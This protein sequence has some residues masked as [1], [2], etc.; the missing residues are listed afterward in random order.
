MPKN[1]KTLKKTI[2]LLFFVLIVCF[3][4]TVPLHYTN[5]QEGNVDLSNTDI[6]DSPGVDNNTSFD[7]EDW[8]AFY[9]ENDG[10]EA[11]ERREEAATTAA[12]NYEPGLWDFTGHLKNFV[13]VLANFLLRVSAWFLG[14]VGLILNTVVFFSIENMSMIVDGG[15]MKDTWTIFRDLL[16]ILFIFG[17]LFISIKT[18][19][20]TWGS[21]TKN[22]L[23]NI[24][25]AG[26]LINFSFFFTSVFIDLS[27]IVTV[28]IYDGMTECRSTANSTRGASEGL[29]WVS[30]KGL[31]DCWVNAL[32]L[33]SVY[34]V[35]EAG[36]I[37]GVTSNSS[38]EFFSILQALFLGSAVITVAAIVFGV[39]AVTL[40]VRFVVLVFLL[41]TSPVMFAGMILP[42]LKGITSKWLSALQSNLLFAPLAFLFIFIAY[43]ITVTTNLLSTSVGSN[44]QSM[45]GW[46]K[47]FSA[48]GTQTIQVLMN[49]FIIIVFLVSA[50]IIAK[51]VGNAITSKS[52]S[53]GGKLV[54][55]GILGGAAALG[56]NTIGRGA[57][58]LAGNMKG[59]SRLALKTKATL[60]SVGDSS[61]NARN[62]RPFKGIASA[63]GIDLGADKKGGFASRQ[64][65][66]AKAIQETYKDLGKMTP[67]DLVEV[68]KLKQQMNIE[69]ADEINERK[70][71]EKRIKSSE[72]EQKSHVKGSKDYDD[73][74]QGIDEDKAAVNKIN[75]TIQRSDLGQRIKKVEGRGKEKQK[76]YLDRIGNMNSKMNKVVSVLTKEREVAAGIISANDKKKNQKD[77]DK[78]ISGISSQI[79]KDKS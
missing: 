60:K 70:N 65:V 53:W 44:T 41:I 63:T 59:T 75:F 57:A 20:G 71:I 36:N 51:S 52:M 4:I 54:G 16:N 79:N 27:N 30:G 40:L 15:I 74:Q 14:V 72:A 26:L 39:I 7:E 5:A 6:F 58:R 67:K 37:I 56:R 23:K 33:T 55:G 12:G 13:I 62:T 21:E 32:K 49:Y 77:T 73:Y 29:V 31:S 76:E 8:G 69:F 66:K 35:K 45:G 68:V 61:F 38:D 64:D 19:I 50:I 2:G 1:K 10:E 46:A 42:N 24:I 47:A 18:I 43:K 25:I 28:K 9:E 48:G 22:L 34:N 3:V 17:L 78:I 11:M